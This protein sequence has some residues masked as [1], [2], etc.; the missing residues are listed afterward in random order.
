M[1]GRVADCTASMSDRMGYWA[2]RNWA[3]ENEDD[4]D[5]YTFAVAGSVG[6]ILCEIWDW[7]EGVKTD[8][9]LAIGYGRGLQTVNILRNS[10]ED[11]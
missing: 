5:I 6:L 3:I 7:F 4:L 8:R 2:S 9:G 1:R 10:G 11:K